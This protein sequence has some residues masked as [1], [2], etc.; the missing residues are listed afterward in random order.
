VGLVH[1]PELAVCPKLIQDSS[2][3]L[4]GIADSLQKASSSFLMKSD[5]NVKVRKCKINS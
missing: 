3:P 5:S 1:G 4:A 2:T